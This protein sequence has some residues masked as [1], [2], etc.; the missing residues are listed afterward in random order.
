MDVNEKICIED[1]NS[2]WNSFYE[3]EKVLIQN[4]L[5][6]I[7]IEHIGST[8]IEGMKAKPIID[9]LIGVN[10]FPPD[11][12][13]ITILQKVGYTYMKEASVADRLYFVK[14][15]A[16]SFNV[17]IVEKESNIWKADLAFR[18]YMSGNPDE[19]ARYAALKTKII[20]SGVDTLLEY[21]ALKADYIFTINNLVIGIPAAEKVRYELKKLSIDDGI[22]VFSMLQELPKEENG[23][24]NTAYGKTFQEFKE[25]LLKENNMSQGI[26]LESWMVPQNTYWFYVN[27]VI[28]GTAKLRHYLTD[29]LR[30]EGGHGGYA[31][32]ASERNKGYGTILLK[33]LKEE[34]ARL[35]IDKMF[36]TIRNDNQASIKVALNNDAIIEKK[37][38]VRQF[39]WIK[40]Q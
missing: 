33:L 20:D 8:S 30:N 14:R 35:D 24:V 13:V 4:N 7:L 23:F 22:D 28:A 6:N 16:I 29:T 1:Y 36:L 19:M 40:C 21:S 10:S 38:D 2:S 27:G 3:K 17:H 25:W 26:N 32:K 11:E 31:V 12:N 15:S 37:S 39:L 34:A 9:I 5:K 18:D